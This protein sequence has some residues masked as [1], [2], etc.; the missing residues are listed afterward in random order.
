MERAKVSAFRKRGLRPDECRDA[1]PP[2]WPIKDS[3]QERKAGTMKTYILGK[4]PTVEPQKSTTLPT[5]PG[6]TLFV[7]LDV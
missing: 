3:N 1:E 7:G 5:P 2:V 4:F 6:A